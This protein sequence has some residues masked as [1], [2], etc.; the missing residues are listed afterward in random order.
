MSNG[1]LRFGARRE[2][3]G[4][5]ARHFIAGLPCPAHLNPRH[6][7]IPFHRNKTQ[8][9]LALRIRLESQGPPH[10][11]VGAPRLIGIPPRSPS[12]GSG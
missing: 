6:G 11:H 1:D 4:S 10:H 12:G 3:D 8:Q 5:G 9:Q 7:R 2:Q